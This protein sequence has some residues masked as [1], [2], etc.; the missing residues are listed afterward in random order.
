MSTPVMML[1]SILEPVEPEAR[2]MYQN[3][4]NLVERATVEHVVIP[5]SK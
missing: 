4:C 1:W 3:L 2:T 5:K